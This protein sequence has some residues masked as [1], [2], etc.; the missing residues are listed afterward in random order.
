M[1]LFNELE[2]SLIGNIKNLKLR[3]MLFIKEMMNPV[4][5]FK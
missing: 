3:N 2:G 5:Y 4:I 1:N